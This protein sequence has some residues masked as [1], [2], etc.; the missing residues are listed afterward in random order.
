MVAVHSPSGRLRIRASLAKRANSVHLQT[1]VVVST[2]TV[3]I[4]VVASK[5]ARTLIERGLDFRDARFVFEGVTVEFVDRRKN[6]RELRIVCY[7]LLAGRMVV[8]GYTPRGDSRHVFSMRKANQREQARLAP[9][10]EV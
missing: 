4:T 8:I 7:G 6:Y 5:C 3:R 2:L 9:Y 1:A 10:F